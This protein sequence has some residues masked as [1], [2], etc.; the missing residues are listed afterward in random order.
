MRKL[1]L[2]VTLA[3]AAVA[4]SAQ[5]GGSKQFVRPAPG[6]T[7]PYSMAIKAGNII[8][9][10]GMLPTDEK[11]QLVQGDLKVQAK[12][13]FDNLR[14]TLQQAGSS[15]DQAVAAT[16]MLQK[17]EDFPALDAIYKEQ[18]KN[19]PPVRTTIIGD[20]VRPGALLEI[21][22]TAVPN[23]VQRRVILP[24]GWMKPSSPYTLSFSST[25]ALGPRPMRQVPIGW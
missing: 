17:A 18:F 10:S 4:L 16:V 19:E 9:V 8:Y 20:M 22:V 24:P 12:Q 23:G 11:G 15:L 5:M 6:Q 25:T 1:T 21:Q 14:N 3:S 2:T 13:V 7:P